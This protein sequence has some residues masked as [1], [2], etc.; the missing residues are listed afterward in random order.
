MVWVRGE[1]GRRGVTEGGEGGRRG[2][3]GRGRREGEG[4]DFW[5]LFGRPRMMV[6]IGFGN[7][8]PSFDATEKKTKT[9]EN[10]REWEGQAPPK[11][12]GRVRRD[13]TPEGRMGRLEIVIYVSKLEFSGS[14]TSELFAFD[15]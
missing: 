13:P 2:E 5:E 14:K 4:R 1:K 12:K 3:E 15:T 11:S 8:I 9:K 6:S 10:T 7:L